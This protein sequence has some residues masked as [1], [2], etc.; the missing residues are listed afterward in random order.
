[1]EIVL[2]DALN[3]IALHSAFLAI[4]PRIE[5]HG[6]IYF[7]HLR[8]PQSKED[9]IQEMRSLAWKWLLRLTRKG[10]DVNDF[11]VTF[12]HLLA[13]AVASGRRLGG[14]PKAKDV[15]NPATQKRH[16]FRVESLDSS[17]RSSL[18]RLYAAP[19]GQELQDAFEERL[20][21]NTRT[22]VPEQVGFRIDFP[23]WVTSRAE[24]DRR[25]VGDLMAGE[26]TL[27]VAR[28]Y[29]LSPGRVSQLRSE[30][31]EDWLRFTA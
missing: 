30:F 4:L 20:C 9:A 7:R 31:H 2:V 19:H 3:L 8:C 21:D 6:Q 18:E 14:M 27:D 15:L 16:G 26:R 13:R 12:V 28:K 29:G 25:I 23:A 24:R 22:E 5:L 11:P 10:K 17:T 1:M